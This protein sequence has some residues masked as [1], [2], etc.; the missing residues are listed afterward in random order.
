MTN[1]ELVANENDIKK[2]FPFTI[3]HYTY[4]ILLPKCVLAHGTSIAS[5]YFQI[6]F[7][8]NNQEK[9]KSWQ[10][11]KCWK[12]PHKIAAEIGCNQRKVKD[13]LKVLC[14]VG[15]LELSMHGKLKMYKLKNNSFSNLKE[16]M[17]FM[18][19]FDKKLIATA[20][21]KAKELRNQIHEF[22]EASGINTINFLKDSLQRTKIPDINF[23]KETFL[24]V[25]Q[26]YKG[27]SLFF[28]N[29]LEIDLKNRKKNHS[30]LN[31]I[32]NIKDDIKHPI[33]LG[34]SQAT[35]NRYLTVYRESEKLISID[36]GINRLK[37][38]KDIFVGRELNL[39]R[40]KVIKM[41]E[42][43][44]YCPICDR[45]FTS[46]RA[47]GMHLGKSKD[48]NHE[49]LNQLRYEKRTP[50]S[51]FSQLVKDNSHLFD[52]SEVAE[53]N[54]EVVDVD[55]IKDKYMEIPCEC[56]MSCR[57]CHLNWHDD[58]FKGCNHIRKQAYMEEYGLNGKR[59]KKSSK[60]KE[61]DFG[62]VPAAK[63]PVNHGPDTAPG[64]LKYFYDMTGGR[65]PNFG[66][67]VG[68]VKAQI[69]KGLTPDE[70]RV[71]LN[72]MVRKGQIDLRFFSTSINDALIE[73]KYLKE[74]EQEGT[75]AYLLQY[76]YHGHGLSINLQ[77]FVREVQKIQETMNSGL[78]YDETKIVLDYM[79]AQKCTIV[80]FIASKRTEALAK[81]KAQNGGTQSGFKVNPSFFDQDTLNII[82]DDLAGGRTHI[83]KV[84][85]KYKDKALE[86]AKQIY[87]EHKF[88]QRYTMF[89]WA[90]RTGVEL[91][92][93]MYQLGV[94]EIGK[95]TYIDFA[96][97]NK[98][99]LTSEKLEMI[100][101]LKLSFEK[102]LER[103]HY[104][105][106]QS[107]ISTI[108]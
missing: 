90:W 39:S 50:Y 16:L 38:N 61:V 82:R 40:G 62:E 55:N 22:N 7:N 69:K 2:P 100:N 54:D 88:N 56:K 97:R 59:E 64:L 42:K 11:S 46:G 35:L 95:E 25:E 80:N 37:D 102:W 72:H 44:F 4:K 78:T 9:A 68:Q 6:A 12:N 36:K 10:Q 49:V 52:F 71:V 27:S 94:K 83:N 70:I 18:A 105:F 84:E 24:E 96:L 26:L 89:E 8:I 13:V 23:M 53:T 28:M 74:M 91:D 87:K 101:K 32:Q 92:R 99:K 47:L 5:T 19:E 30:I 73:Q 86:I 79:I 51:E 77:T 41:S 14:D 20:F 60:G 75:A 17:E 93:E 57:T 1:I 45:D 106:G 48:K 29:L 85:L 58:F 21:Y 98:D 107:H 65:S 3:S 104:T 31:T 33:I 63:K 66:K 103:Q 81:H 43:E 76:F 108:N 15:M 34:C 67:E